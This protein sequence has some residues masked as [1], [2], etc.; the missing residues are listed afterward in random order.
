MSE[1]ERREFVTRMRERGEKY[2]ADIIAVLTPNQ[3]ADWEKMQGKKFEFPAPQ[4][5]RRPGG[6]R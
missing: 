3:K 6:D 2:N 1:D 5:G 4:F